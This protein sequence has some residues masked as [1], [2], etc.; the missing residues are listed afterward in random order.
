MSTIK[1]YYVFLTFFLLWCVLSVLWYA[2][3]VRGLTTGPVAFSGHENA[4]AILEILLMVL[5]AFLIGYLVAYYQ[6]EEPLSA[7]RNAHRE[8]HWKNHQLMTGWQQRDNERRKSEEMNARLSRALEKAME[9]KDDE[10]RRL[11]GL[12]EQQKSDALAARHE[13]EEGQGRIKQLAAEVAHLKFKLKQQEYQDENRIT[14]RAPKEDEIDDLTEIRGIG[15]LIARR[16]Y[17]MGIYSFRQISQL[18][19]TTMGQIGKALKHFPDRI[20]RDNWV[21]QAKQ[22]IARQ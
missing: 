11:S 6:Q 17:A 18:D 10:Y 5:G 12:V 13:L 15:P 19:Q 14:L 16:L 4:L 9:V 22:R 2:L 3:G 7:L 21:G 1:W 8:L 20:H